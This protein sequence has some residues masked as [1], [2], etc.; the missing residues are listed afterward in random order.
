LLVGEALLDSQQMKGQ[1][2]AL[3]S[4]QREQ[5]GVVLKLSPRTMRQLAERQVASILE[6]MGNG[7]E[8]W[9]QAF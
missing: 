9:N 6:F 7:V 5:I 2:C 3:G 1:L 4:L 8:V